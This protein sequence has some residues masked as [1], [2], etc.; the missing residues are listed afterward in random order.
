[1]VMWQVGVCSV[2]ALGQ[3]L[4]GT[5]QATTPKLLEAVRWLQANIRSPEELAALAAK[6]DE[7]EVDEEDEEEDYDDEDEDGDRGGQDRKGGMF[8]FDFSEYFGDDEEEE[9]EL[10][11]SSVNLEPILSQVYGMYGLSPQS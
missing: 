11:I 2:L 6:D 5:L 9:I 8:D 7:D 3:S 1:M 4:P 10:P